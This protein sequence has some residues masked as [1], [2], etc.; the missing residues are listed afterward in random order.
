MISNNL[1]L[2]F[3]NLRKQKGFAIINILGL[4]V[5]I[6]SV[7][8]IFRMVQF[9]LGFNKNFRHYD[10]IVRVCTQEKGLEGQE[11][12]TRGVPIPA[13]SE[14]K[15][16]ITQFAATSRIKEN[17]PTV[18]VP[19][20]GGGAPLKKFNTEEGEIALFAEPAFLDIFDFGWLAGNQ[21][22][23]LKE[24]NTLVLSQ[25]MA[26]KCFGSWQNAVGQT[27]LI[28]NEPMMVQGVI[29]N[30]PPQCDFPINML[31]SYQ[32]LISS[33]DKYEYRDDWGST[34]SNDQIF[35]LLNNPAQFQEANVAVEKVGKKQYVDESGGQSSYKG[36]LL[37]PLAGMH[38]DD[39]FGTFATHVIS[40]S[41]LWVLSSIGLLILLMACFNFINLST[42]QAL[43]RSRE[44]GVRKTLGGS[45]AALFGQFMSETAMIVGFSVLLGTLIAWLGLPLLERISE[46]PTDLPFLNQPVLW[47]FIS[48]L[49]LVVTLL[50]GFYPALVLAGFNPIKALKNDLFN[51]A[52]SGNG[53][54]K[55][56]VV[57]QFLIAQALIVGTI[58]T[59]GQLDYLRN[60]DMGFRKELVYTF[61]MAG[62]SIAQS[63]MSGFKQRLLQIPGVESVSFSSDQPSSG[64]TWM[65]NF[66]VGRGTDYQRFNTTIKYGDADFLQTYGMKMVAGRWLEPSDTVKEYVVNET[67]VKKLG[68]ANPEEILQKELRMGSGK[69]RKIV[70]VIQDFH[71]HSAHRELEPMTL[72]SNLER[73]YV[74][75][76][77][78]KPQNIKATTEAIQKVHDE[79]FAEQ[80]FDASFFDEQIADFYLDENRF[81]DT[82]KGFGAIAIFISCLGLLGLATH[83]AQ[84]R[85]KEIGIRKVL[86]AGVSG[87]TMLLA[88]DFLKL[89]LIAIV[90]AS[91]LAYYLMDKWLQDFSYRINIQ[92]WMFVLAGFVAILIAFLTVSLQ[93]V[94]AALAN[95]IKS[96]R[97]E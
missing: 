51:Q 68:I 7:L 40:K 46:V 11:S 85:T 76:V 88:K 81:S 96:L 62:D 28:D 13:M 61:N 19:N 79:T 83:A 94:K 49:A 87:I 29:T 89:V 25:K 70:G 80:V 24:P 66:A 57:M 43:R 31:I 72:S 74:T 44:V 67:M 73:F 56:L 22:N 1:K 90:I 60:M 42:A 38:Y 78:I 97:S 39:R 20:P 18:L 92:W 23:I 9:E 26:E 71:A 27:L 54:R 63:R 45:H 33:P 82:C 12:F 77:K 41:R 37:Q 91:P 48:A 30:A 93:S 5:G 35:A 4:S 36:H 55:G 52:S 95:P 10:R 75:G 8:L 6:A 69:W 14:I 84:R 53:L 2:A 58:I 50:S 65:T 3:R 64:S 34:S 47:I 32:T 59:L 86:G 15:N 17:W 21:G 16:T